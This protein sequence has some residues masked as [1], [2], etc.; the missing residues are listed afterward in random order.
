MKE[1][2]LDKIE[3]YLNGDMTP[4][5][6][7]AFDAAIEKDAELAAAVDNFGV[8]NDALEILIEDNLRKEL[9]AM[10][11]EQASSSNVVSINKK[12][13]VARMRNLRTYLAAAASVA[14]LVGFIGWNWASS[15]FTN[16][17]LSNEFSSEYQMPNVRAGNSVV[18]A[19]ADGINAYN[20]QNY[21]EA[22]QF[23][24]SVVVDDPRYAEAQFYLGHTL[25]AQEKAAE[26]A[27]QFQKVA[28]PGTAGR[29][30]GS[31]GVS[32]T[33]VA[34]PRRPRPH[35]TSPVPGSTPT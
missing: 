6:E 27:Q 15:N 16:S 24:S 22:N 25:L 9:E 4:K 31:L 33:R 17:A 23:F 35:G 10:S 14:L 12:Q 1:E 32:K 20:A 8:A 2:L 28:F 21:A 34:R 30:A 3:A 19:F 5:A 11:Q 18:N 7:A 29:F 13:P 26:A